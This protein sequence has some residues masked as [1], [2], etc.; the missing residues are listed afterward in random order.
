MMLLSQLQCASILYIVFIIIIS[1]I[2]MVASIDIVHYAAVDPPN[3]F[4]SYVAVS[5]SAADNLVSVGNQVGSGTIVRS[6]DGGLSWTTSIYC[7]FYCISHS[8]EAKMRDV[9]FDKNA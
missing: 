5:F 9:C 6:T 3:A 4:F 7:K 8:N 1:L 2:T